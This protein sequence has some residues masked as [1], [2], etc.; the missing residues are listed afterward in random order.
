VVSHAGAEL[1]RELADASG[2]VDGWEGALLGTYKAI[3]PHKPGRV[4]ADLAVASADGATAISHVAA[5]RDQPALFGPVASTRQRGV[6]CIG[7]DRISWRGSGGARNSPALG[8]GGGRRTRPHGRVDRRFRGW[9]PPPRIR[10]RRRREN[11][12]WGTARWCVS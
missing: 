8:L 9:S 1:L 12:R 11:G 3:P 5:L 7:S 4:L 6:Y 2:L 10:R